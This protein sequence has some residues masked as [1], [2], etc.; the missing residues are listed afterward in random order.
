MMSIQFGGERKI[1]VS[2]KSKEIYDELVT[3]EKLLPDMSTMFA[4]AAS[5]GLLE[6]KRKPLETTDELVNVY[7]FT[8]ATLFELLITWKHPELEPDGRLKVLQ[9]YAEYGVDRIYDHF[10]RFSGIDI[11]ILVEEAKGKTEVV[12]TKL[13]EETGTV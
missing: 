5:L 1:A 6:G 13:H 8:D 10:Q 2:K 9:E 7:S 12:E 11:S 4:L 3:R